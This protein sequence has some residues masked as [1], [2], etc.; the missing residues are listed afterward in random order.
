M[1]TLPPVGGGAETP[2]SVA[3]SGRTLYSARSCTSAPPRASEENTSCPTGTEP[4]SKRTM[5]GGSVPLGMKAVARKA[6]AVTCASDCAMSVPG[7]KYS[8][9]IAMP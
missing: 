9:S 8:F 3:S 1:R 2:G 7:W 5:K 4:T 6:I